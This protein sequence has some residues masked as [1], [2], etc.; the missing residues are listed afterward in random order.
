[1]PTPVTPG[2]ATGWSVAAVAPVIS[3]ATPPLFVPV[4]VAAPILQLVGTVLLVKI[5]RRDAVSGTA[6]PTVAGL[7]VMSIES[8]LRS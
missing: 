4:D 5:L 2:V 7:L 6:L 1:M 8:E 3:I